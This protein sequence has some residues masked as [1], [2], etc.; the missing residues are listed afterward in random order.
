MSR[1]FLFALLLVALT[2]ATGEA[3]ILCEKD[4][5]KVLQCDPEITQAKCVARGAAGK[6]EFREKGG[7]CG[8]CSICVQ[9][10]SKSNKSN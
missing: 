5:C 10:L 1:L 2:W 3:A 9:I 6:F 8:C 4:T 7:S